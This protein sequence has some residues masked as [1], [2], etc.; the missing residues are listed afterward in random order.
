MGV[1]APSPLEL[2]GRGL[3]NFSKPFLPTFEMQGLRL[4]LVGM[5]MDSVQSLLSMSLPP[6]GSQVQMPDALSEALA[7]PLWTASPRKWFVQQ[8][9]IILDSYSVSQE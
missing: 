8:S 5:S 6:D 2:L 3:I 7:G 1:A 9:A 4:A